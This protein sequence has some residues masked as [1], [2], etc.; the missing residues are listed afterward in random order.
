MT[1]TTIGRNNCLAQV[2]RW[3]VNLMKPK[4]LMVDTPPYLSMRW[5]HPNQLKNSGA[6]QTTPTRP[7]HRPTRMLGFAA[8]CKNNYRGH[9]TVGE[10]THNQPLGRNIATACKPKSDRQPLPP[11]IGRTHGTVFSL[12]LDPGRALNTPI[13][14]TPLHR[15]PA[16]VT[17]T[18]FA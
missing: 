2:R 11:S 16:L 10:R 17:W 6:I 13:T 12:Q 4:C 14:G 3:R 8:T 5:G 18:G 1:T 9:S 7:G 15:A